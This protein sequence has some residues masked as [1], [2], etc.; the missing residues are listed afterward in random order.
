MV[1]APFLAPPAL[2]DWAI[3]PLTRFIG[4]LPNRLLWW[5]PRLR[6]ALEGPDHAY[7]RFATHSLAWV[8]AIGLNTF[9]SSET[10]APAAGRVIMVNSAS[11]SAINISRAES[12][13]QNWEKTAPDR[14]TEF[15][16]PRELGVPHD[17]ID[18]TQPDARVEI[19]YPELLRLL[20]ER[21]PA[22]S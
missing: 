11:D 1:I 4:R 5:D 13:A 18:P 6:D 17:S 8:M 9:R 14:V 19:V 12:L 7:R 22:G 3:A 20:G 2:P 10:D 16:F 15:I 21:D